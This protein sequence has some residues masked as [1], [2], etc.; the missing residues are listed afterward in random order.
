MD[1]RA[2]AVLVNACLWKIHLQSKLNACLLLKLNLEI[3]FS[4]V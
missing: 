2:D 4:Y 1:L 3:S